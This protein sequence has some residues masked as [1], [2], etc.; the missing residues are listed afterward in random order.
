MCRKIINKFIVTFLSLSLFLTGCGSTYDSVSESPS[1]TVSDYTD[2]STSVD[3]DN[4]EINTQED[5]EE[6]SQDDDHDTIAS[7]YSN[8]EDYWNAISSTYQHVKYD[9]ITTGRYSDHYVIIDGIIDN[10]DK[11]LSFLEYDIYY[12]SKN[13][14][15]VSKDNLADNENNLRYSKIQSLENGDKVQLCVYVN[16]DNSFGSDLLSLNILGKTK[17]NIRKKIKNAFIKACK[18]YSYK[19][20][21]HH[22]K[23]YKGKK[24]KFTGRVLQTIETDEYY[25]DLRISVESDIDKVYYVSYEKENNKA[26]IL[27]NDKVTV[28]GTLDGEETYTTIFGEEITLPSVEAEY[29]VV[30]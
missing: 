26:K 4:N 16:S 11:D 14:Y 2:D 17:G 3:Q 18:S 6:E 21:A 1:P 12:K 28:Y 30:K 25:T 19:T 24:I 7:Q 20:I 8:F 22:P 9:D 13:S 5:Y 10:I 29:I 15:K 23:K 27:K